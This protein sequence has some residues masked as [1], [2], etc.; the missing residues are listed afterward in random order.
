LIQEKIARPLGDEILFGR[1][2]H[3]GHVEVDAGAEGVVLNYMEGFGIQ[4]SGFRGTAN[5]D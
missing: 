1:L 4:D 5:D 3:G 2:E